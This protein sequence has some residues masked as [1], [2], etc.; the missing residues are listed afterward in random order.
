MRRLS[1]STSRNRHCKL[2]QECAW[3]M[4]ITA[5]S[6][7]AQ[8]RGVKVAGSK[9]MPRGGA[10]EKTMSSFGPGRGAGTSA[11]ILPVART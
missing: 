2:P 8:R 10:P 9:V 5:S 1:H 3:K 7:F 4:W 6:G 11:A